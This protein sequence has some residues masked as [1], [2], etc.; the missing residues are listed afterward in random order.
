[1]KIVIEIDGGIIKSSK[2][3]LQWQKF[4]YKPLSVK[5]DENTNSKLD[6]NDKKK[7]D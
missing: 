1:M 4:D 2:V 3:L 7:P 5:K 6:N